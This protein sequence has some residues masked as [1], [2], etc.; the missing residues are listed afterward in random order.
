MEQLID[1]LSD[2]NVVT[3]NL[4]FVQGVMTKSCCFVRSLSFR[5]QAEMPRRSRSSPKPFASIQAFTM[6]WFREHVPYDLPTRDEGL[7]KA[8]LPEE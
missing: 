7:R 3:G 6:K 4:G 1:E 5:F 8:G 2:L